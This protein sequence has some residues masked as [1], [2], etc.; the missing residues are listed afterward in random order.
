MGTMIRQQ[1]NQWE[2]AT[3]FVGKRKVGG[4]D[5]SRFARTTNT[6]EQRK[7]TSGPLT[8]GVAKR[9]R[10]V[11]TQICASVPIVWQRAKGQENADK[12]MDAL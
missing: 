4:G 1:W 5:H 3:N 8:T 7:T 2:P 6:R 11:D 12:T 9:D 10:L